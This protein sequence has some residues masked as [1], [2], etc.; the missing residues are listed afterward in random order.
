MVNPMFEPTGPWG[1]GYLLT[2]GTSFRSYFNNELL[3]SGKGL[4]AIKDVKEKVEKKWCNLDIFNYQS[5]NVLVVKKKKWIHLSCGNLIYVE[6]D[7][8]FPLL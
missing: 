5:L 1:E 8:A 7:A 6:S 4:D 2:K 3:A